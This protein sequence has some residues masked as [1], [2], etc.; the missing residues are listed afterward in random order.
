MGSEC[1]NDQSRL[2]R[3]GDGESFATSLSK[4]VVVGYATIQELV[5]GKA[6]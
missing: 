5:W 6:G 4:G 1:Q 2:N 3:V